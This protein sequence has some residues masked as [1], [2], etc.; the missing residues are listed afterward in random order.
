MY[1]VDSRNLPKKFFPIFVQDF[2]N[3]SCHCL[4]NPIEKF[5]STPEKGLAKSVSTFEKCP[6]AAE[7][8]LK[9][10]QNGRFFMFSISA[11]PPEGAFQMSTLF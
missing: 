7:L 1:Y 2:L 3:L 8:K 4:L 10:S 5:N 11:L 9:M 6:L